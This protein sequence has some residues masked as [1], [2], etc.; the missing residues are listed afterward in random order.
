V[1][2]PAVEKARKIPDKQCRF[3]VNITIDTPIAWINRIGT[4][5]NTLYLLAGIAVIS[6][7]TPPNIDLE[8]HTAAFSKETFF[9][10]LFSRTRHEK[11]LI[12]FG[13]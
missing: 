12:C 13:N 1:S 7:K 6:G 4:G 11:Y 10:Q 5:L 8:W 3:V 2:T 9:L